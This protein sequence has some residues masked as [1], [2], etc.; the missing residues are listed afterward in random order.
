MKRKVLITGSNGLLGQK[1]VLALRQ[2]DDVEVYATARGENRLSTTGG[3][4]YIGVDIANEQEVLAIVNKVKPHVIINTAAM[5][6]VDICETQRAEC[7]EANVNA[8][9]NLIKASEENDVHLV[10]VSTDFIFDGNPN[11][12][13]EK[14]LEDDHAH[15]VNYYG[16]S[17]LAAEE[18]VKLSNCR[19]SIVRT[20]LVYGI[21][22]NMS[23]TNIVLW[24]KGELEKGK[25]VNVVDDQFRSPTL[26]ED[27]AQACILIA[28][29]KADGVFH[30]SGRDYMS[31]YEMVRQIAIFYNFDQSLINP[32]NTAALKQ[33]AVRPPKTGFV[34]SKAV[35]VLGYHPHTFEEG[36]MILDHQLKT[37]K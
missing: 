5:T 37:M 29:K 31:I 35:S 21:A 16:E 28:D 25:K 10:H 17:K 19:W 15:P 8:V 34:I 11:K 26:A 2:R 36:I 7:W 12:R 23:R 22:E 14:Y 3:Y 20:S 27:L 18:L 13:R 33:A 4:E 24:A 1:I 32:V 30:I 6:N 9:A